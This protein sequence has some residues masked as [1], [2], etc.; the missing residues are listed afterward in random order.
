MVVGFL[1]LL[2][3]VGSVALK[4][5][6]GSASVRQAAAQAAA[7]VEQARSGAMSQGMGTRLVIDNDPS[8]EHYLRRIAVFVP[9]YSEASGMQDGWKLANRPLILPAGIFLL[10]DY[11][12]GWSSQES[13]VFGGSGAQAGGPC[14]VLHFDGEGRLDAN[15]AARMVFSRALEPAST[16]PENFLEGRQGILIRKYGVPAFFQTADQMPAGNQP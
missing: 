3:A 10:P 1:G 15:G 14:F 6:T 13:Y 7:M 9:D 4:D 16:P 5:G 11:S 12:W 8:S 2:A